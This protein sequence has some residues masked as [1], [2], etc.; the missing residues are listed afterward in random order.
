LEDTILSAD[1]FSGL[2]ISHA[3]VDKL[4]GGIGDLQ[5]ER[6]YVNEIISDILEHCCEQG[7]KFSEKIPVDA[8]FNERLLGAKTLLLERMEKENIVIIFCTSDRKL[9]ELQLTD[10]LL[11]SMFDRLEN[12]KNEATLSN[13]GG[14][15][16]N[17]N[18]TNGKPKLTVVKQRKLNENGQ[19]CPRRTFRRTGKKF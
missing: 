2:L 6:G 4:Y 3:L 15:Q 13:S 17:N 14:V 11:Q 8:L 9:R 7:W 5:P 10:S 18:A 1:D 19:T 12:I 16:S